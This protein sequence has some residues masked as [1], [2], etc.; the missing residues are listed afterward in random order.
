MS[1]HRAR[2]LQRLR[3]LGCVESRLPQIRRADIHGDVVE[4]TLGGR[5]DG[6]EV[7]RAWRDAMRHGRSGERALPRER[8]RLI[9][10]ARHVAGR[11]RE[12]AVHE[13]ASLEDSGEAAHGREE[14]RQ[15]AL[16]R[17]ALAELPIDGDG[18]AEVR[19]P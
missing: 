12:A 2:G 1:R 19:H 11:R 16:P 7:V 9:L 5:V 8:G 15:R 10:E 14:L 3:E 4:G 18:S 13:R 6:F 17:V